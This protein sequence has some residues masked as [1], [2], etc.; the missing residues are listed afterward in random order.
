MQKLIIVGASI[1]GGILLLL[2][3]KEDEESEKSEDPSTKK[4]SS[5]DEQINVEEI[6]RLRRELR[7]QVALKKKITNSKKPP[8]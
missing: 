3:T 5:L 6:R 4:N 8:T 7:H 2:A 1:V